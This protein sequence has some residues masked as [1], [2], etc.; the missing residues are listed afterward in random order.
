MDDQ[1]I[2]ITNYGNQLERAAWFLTLFSMLTQLG[3]DVAFPS[4]NVAL[5]FW[6][7]YCA[8]SRHGRAT[9]GFITFSFFGIIFDIVFCSINGSKSTLY[10]FS[11]AMLILCLVLKVYGLYVACFFFTFIGGAASL[12]DDHNMESMYESMRNGDDRT[13]SFSDGRPG[14]GQGQG[15]G[16]HSNNVP[17]IGGRTSSRGGSNPKAMDHSRGQGA[18]SSGYSHSSSTSSNSSSSS[19]RG[20][21]YPPD[22]VILD[23]GTHSGR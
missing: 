1:E 5:G 6:G 18:G 21:Y 16:Q 2:T 22:S 20:G 7:A 17:R 11:L 8:F 23:S 10:K 15:Q 9:F 3:G 4:Y 14:Q 13:I 19:Q 12:Q